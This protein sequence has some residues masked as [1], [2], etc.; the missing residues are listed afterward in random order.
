MKERENEHLSLINKL[1]SELEEKNKQMT[2]LKKFYINE[3]ECSKEYLTKVK[4]LKQNLKN[5]EKIIKYTKKTTIDLNKSLIQLK[6]Q[7]TEEKCSV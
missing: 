1:K 7:L 2:D 5:K 3:L 4:D 6:L